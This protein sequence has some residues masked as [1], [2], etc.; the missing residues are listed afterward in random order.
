M[1]KDRAPDV[2]TDGFTRLRSASP[3][4]K[5]GCHGIPSSH[6]PSGVGL[7]LHFLHARDADFDTAVRCQAGDQLILALDAVTLGAGD[8]VGFT[9]AFDGDLAGGQTLADQEVGHGAG[10]GF[11]QLLVISLGTDAIAVTNDDGQGRRM[12]I[13]CAS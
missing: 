4:N 9:T 1:Q 11:G 2:V 6:P 12:I 3:T 10:T 13:L 8:R 5:R 7:L